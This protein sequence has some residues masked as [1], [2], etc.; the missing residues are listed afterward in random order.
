MFFMVLPM[1]SVITVENAC[2]LFFSCYMK[3]IEVLNF[4]F[5]FK[6]SSVITKY[7]LKGCWFCQQPEQQKGRQM[8]VI[9][10]SSVCA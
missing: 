3:S 1:V 5:F 7:I 8:L 6:K 10:C 9:G 4:S 2:S